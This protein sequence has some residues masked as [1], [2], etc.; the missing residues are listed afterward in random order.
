MAN[1]GG[2]KGYPVAKYQK[3]QKSSSL[4]GVYLRKGHNVHIKKVTPVNMSS[5]AKI[6]S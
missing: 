1:K 6:S 4:S 5:C 2:R 3:A